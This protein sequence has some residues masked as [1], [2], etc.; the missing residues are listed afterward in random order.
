MWTPEIWRRQLW[1]HHAAT[2]VR[3]KSR[4]SGLAD[5]VDGTRLPLKLAG[6][7]SSNGLTYGGSVNDYRGK[8]GPLVADHVGGCG[9]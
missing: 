7:L 9:P 4:L 1:Q 8:E 3:R 6:S 5:S 2:V